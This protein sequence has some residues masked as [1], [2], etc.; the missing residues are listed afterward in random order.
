MNGWEWE[1]MRSEKVLWGWVKRKEMVIL[2][3]SVAVGVVM[4]HEKVVYICRH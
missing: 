4:H 2:V 1:G 3:C